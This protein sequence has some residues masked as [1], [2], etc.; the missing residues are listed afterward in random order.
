MLF[1]QTKKNNDPN[2]ENTQEQTQNSKPAPKD[3]PDKH[4]AKN[5]EPEEPTS[6]ST[7]IKSEGQAHHAGEGDNKDVHKET[8]EEPGPNMTWGGKK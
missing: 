8:R 5:P 3:Q 4:P 2:E 6:R 7:G 1:D